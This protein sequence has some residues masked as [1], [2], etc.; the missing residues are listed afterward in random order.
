MASDV[1]GS[2]AESSISLEMEGAIVKSSAPMKL[3]RCSVVLTVGALAFSAHPAFAQTPPSDDVDEAATAPKDVVPKDEA[4]KDVAAKEAEPPKEA[5]ATDATRADSAAYVGFAPPA[6]PLRV[7]SPDASIQFGI[8][9]QPQFEMAGA[10]DADSTSKNL[11]LRRMRLMVGGTL[12]KSFEYFFDTDY[13]DLFKADPASQGGG[14]GKNAPGL[15]IQDAFV[16]FKPAAN[17]LKADAGFMLPPF[18]HNGLQ[19]AGTLYGV[20]Y[21]V[22]TFRRNM[23]NNLDPFGANGQNPAGRD[24]GVQLRGLVLGEHLEYRVGAFQGVRQGPLPASAGNNAVVGGNNFMRVAARVQINV[25]DAEPGYF[26][27]GTYLGSKSVLSVGAFYDVQDHYSS[28]GG[29]VFLDVPAGPGIITAQANF[30]QWDGGTFVKSLP[31]ATVIMAEAGYLIRPLMLSPS[32]RFEKVTFDAP[33][34]SYPSEYRIGGG[35]AFWP[36]GHNSNLKASFTHATRTP[37]PHGFNQ[38][39]LQWQV[40]FY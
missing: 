13:P 35:L 31:K 17:L 10:P 19:G 30:L 33:D 28:R 36:Y 27:Q 39:N 22:N 20:D 4:P 24:L 40:Y 23:A 29:D 1:S 38:I 37:A 25:L 6:R 9:A 8:L 26:Y 7:E 11:F 21:F 12:F 15:N 5:A 2:L 3:S 14:T 34:A 32:F 16:T 18:S